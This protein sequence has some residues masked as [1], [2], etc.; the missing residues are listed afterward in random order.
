MKI[1]HHRIHPA[2]RSWWDTSTFKDECQRGA[3]PGLVW[4][5][6][7]ALAPGHI[8]IPH[9]CKSR[10]GGRMQLRHRQGPK[11][12][13]PGHRLPPNTS[14]RCAS[15]WWKFLFYGL[16]QKYTERNWRLQCPPFV[17]SWTSSGF[18]T[19]SFHSPSWFIETL[20]CT[21]LRFNTTSLVGLW[22]LFPKCFV[23]YS[24]PAPSHFLKSLD[25]CSSFL[26]GFFP[27]AFGLLPSFLD[28]WSD[29]SKL[30][31]YITSLS[32]SLL[33]IPVLENK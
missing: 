11:Q 17:L 6:R 33:R 18:Q 22:I 14:P 2:P 15:R 7:Q 25:W 27:L 16:G 31:P 32:K 20:S 28:C 4:P 23:N 8:H 1:E 29:P 12:G 24:S 19:C 5:W 10:G 9:A 3:S 26:G 30:L 13:K 21:P